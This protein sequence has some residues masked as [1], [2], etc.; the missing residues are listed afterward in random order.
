ML[1]RKYLFLALVTLSLALAAVVGPVSRAQRQRGSVPPP[2]VPPSVDLLADTEKVTVCPGDPAQ[3]TARLTLRANGR[4]PENRSL[5]YR[6]RATG[7]RI[8]GD[9]PTTTWDL[10]GVAP[11]VYTATVEADTSTVPGEGCMAFSSAH[12]VVTECA[13][14]R[15]VCPNVAIYC[16]DTVTLGQPVTFTAEVSGGTAGVTPAYNWTVSNG[17]ITSGQ[18]TPSITV[19]TAGLGGKTI[20]ATFEV[21]GYNL[22]CKATCTAQVPDIPPVKTFDAYHDVNYNNEKA[23]LDD[24]VIWL[25]GHPGSQGYIFA[26]QGAKSR[27]GRARMRAS[28][29]RDYIVNERGIEATRVH[30]LEGPTRDTLT[31]ELYGVEPGQPAPRP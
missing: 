3:S 13:P 28:R 31:M 19:D 10:T 8:E 1:P 12:V 22:P 9:G 26:Y 30:V 24:F 4:S 29:A 6:W 2:N 14:P 17:T 15:P 7:G 27:P 23:R 20:T 11:G 16:P 25:Q 18:G 5:H 21:T